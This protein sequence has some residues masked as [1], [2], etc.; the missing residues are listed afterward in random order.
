MPAP[1]R[2][3]RRVAELTGC[4]RRE[5]D[6]YIQGGWVTV[7]G[8]VV[9]AP[10][11]PIVAQVVEIDPE[12]DLTVAEPATLLL[13]KP[14]GAP[15]ESCARLAN[16]ATRAES[17]DPQVRVLKRHFVRL[18][19]LMPLDDDASG[20]VVLSQDGRVWRR[21]SEDADATEQEYIV[22]V[23]GEL[24]PYGLSKLCDGMLYR[25]RALPRA[26]VS[27]QNEDRLRFAIKAVR[28]GQIRDM[29]AQVG[30]R[31]TAIRRIRIGRIPLAKMPVGQWRYLPLN[32]RF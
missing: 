26:K 8:E 11:H 10:Q 4:S 21:L 14:A 9:D 7:D 6:Q 17:D 32:E 22:D 13:H 12:A 19:P 30:L 3:A 1:V 23:V 20:L 27:W 31:A 2:L 18:T 16:P 25:G 15:F 28:P 5:A 24:A 29:C